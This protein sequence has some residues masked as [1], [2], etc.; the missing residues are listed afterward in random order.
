ME[1]EK[2]RGVGK[3]RESCGA[4]GRN[5]DDRFDDRLDDDMDM[6]VMQPDVEYNWCCL[7]YHV[8]DKTLPENNVDNHEKQADLSKKILVI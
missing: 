1:R 7:V 3:E 4:H 8:W 6:R 2:T 5:L